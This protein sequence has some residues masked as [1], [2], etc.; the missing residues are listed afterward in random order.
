MSEWY[1]VYTR[2]KQLSLVTERFLEFVLKRGSDV[3]LMANLERQVRDL[4]IR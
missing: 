4:I 3:L 1:V 2:A